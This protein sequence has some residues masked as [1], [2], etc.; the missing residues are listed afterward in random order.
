LMMDEEEI[1]AEMELT[2]K[3]KLND[4]DDDEND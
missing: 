1:Y 2:K 3:V 4:S